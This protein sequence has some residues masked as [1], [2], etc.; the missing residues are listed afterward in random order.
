MQ[1][2]REQ[3][4]AQEGHVKAWTIEWDQLTLDQRLAVSRLPLLLLL[5]DRLPH[6]HTPFLPTRS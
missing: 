2:V 4:S 6:A 3:Q 5:R 1:E